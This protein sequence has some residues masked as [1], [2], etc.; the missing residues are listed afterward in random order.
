MS[1]Q[2]SGDQSGKTGII[3]KIK[4]ILD[5]N[6]ENLLII[7]F[8]LII[9]GG[10]WAYMQAPQ[11]P[12]T[13]SGI[14]NETETA[15]EEN[16]TEENKIGETATAEAPKTENNSEEKIS[17]ENS[18]TKIAETPKTEP[19]PVN[20][21]ASDGESITVKAIKGDGL[22]H[23]ARRAL[24]EYLSINSGESLNNEQKI[25]IEDYLR[26]HNS[27]KKVNPNDAF[28]YKNDL[29]K[30]AIEKAKQLNAYQLKN[31]EKYSKLV[32]NL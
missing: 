5:Q 3:D 18:D 21:A 8:V 30:T 17:A 6:R 19:E 26:K 22:T 10:V 1:L 29:I 20:T 25:Y 23:T 31:L 9:I 2:P 7:A 16:K 11:K 12:D 32:K 27:Y 15:P 4:N 28:S 13:S 24:K 14:A